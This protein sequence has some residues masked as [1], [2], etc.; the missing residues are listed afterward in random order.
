MTPTRL[1]PRAPGET[2]SPAYWTGQRW[3]LNVVPFLESAALAT[4]GVP[5]AA[6]VVRCCVALA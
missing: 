1:P 3:C 4:G 6:V 5:D 2:L